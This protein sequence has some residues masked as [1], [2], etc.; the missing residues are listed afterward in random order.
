MEKNFSIGISTY[1][2]IGIST[3]LT[4]LFFINRLSFMNGNNKILLVL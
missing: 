4:S 2:T 3:Y 1:L